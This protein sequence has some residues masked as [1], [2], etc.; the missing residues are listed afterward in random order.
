MK[1]LV[2]KILL[3]ILLTFQTL[4]AISQEKKL[5]QTREIETPQTFFNNY[6]K[7]F[8]DYLIDPENK[9]A[10]TESAEDVSYPAIWVSQGGNKIIANDRDFVL[11]NTQ[12]FIGALRNKG[13]S[14][15]TWDTLDIKPLG[16]NVIIASNIANLYL[17]NGEFYAQVSSTYLLYKEG[18]HWKLFSRIQHSPEQKLHFQSTNLAKNTIKGES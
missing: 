11:K 9:I 1:I 15:I 8:N 16:T 14:R 3:P 5:H 10:L 7:H 2:L 18:N 13:I 6:L 4:P 17:D 12:G